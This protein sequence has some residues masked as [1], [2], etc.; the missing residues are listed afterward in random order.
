MPRLRAHAGDEAEL[1][2]WQELQR[3]PHYSRTHT[4][5]ARVLASVPSIGAFRW[6]SKQAGKGAAFVFYAPPLSAGAFKVLREHRLDGRRRWYW[7]DRALRQAG[8]QRIPTDPRVL[9]GL[10]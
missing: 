8:I 5:A 7:I 2:E 4:A 10:T 6:T 3:T 9:R 1:G